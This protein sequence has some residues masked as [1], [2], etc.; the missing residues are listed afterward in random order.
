VEPIKR[1]P[2]CAEEILVA[3]VKCKHCQSTL[4]LPETRQLGKL[5]TMAALLLAGG[6]AMAAGTFAIKGIELNQRYT[7]AQIIAKFGHDQGVIAGLKMGNSITCDKRLC[8]GTTSI[9]TSTWHVTIFKNTDGTVS[10][11]S[12][13]FDPSEFVEIEGSLR[14]KF[15][16]PAQ[17]DH[18]DMRNAFGTV[19]HNTIEVW[20]SAGGDLITMYHYID[21]ESGLLKVQ[22]AREVAAD[23]AL[24]KKRLGD[25][26]I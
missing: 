20:Q 7:N 11:M 15:G 18:T 23:A 12:G 8:E 22:S 17:V 13:H 5:W 19:F 10:S 16:A 3:A 6:S 26:K 21:A 14:E 2:Y 1:C 4:A 25:G 9:G 24:R